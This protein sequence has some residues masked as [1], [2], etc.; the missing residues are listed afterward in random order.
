[1]Y[2]VP[3]SFSSWRHVKTFWSKI[4]RLLFFPAFVKASPSFYRVWHIF[5]SPRWD[6]TV[7]SVV[8]AVLST[9]DGKSNWL[10]LVST[11]L[12]AKMAPYRTWAS[13]RSTVS[14]CG[15]LQNYCACQKTRD[16]PVGRR[17]GMYTALQY[18]CKRYSTARCRI[19][20][21]HSHQK[22]HDT[23]VNYHVSFSWKHSRALCDY[24]LKTDP[25]FLS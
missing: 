22:V 14:C 6:L 13:I 1:M 4:F 17:R 15:Q 7:I 19:S 12:E 21:R 8:A 10:H 20:L 18:Y 9:V 5:T 16:L 24:V 3:P 25:V 23:H 11:S 2:R